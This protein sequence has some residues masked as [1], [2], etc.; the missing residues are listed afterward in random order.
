MASPVVFP[1][2]FCPCLTKKFTVIGTIG[3]TQGITSASSPPPAEKSRKANRPCSAF[4]ATSLA[5][6]SSASTA[7]A[8]PGTAAGPAG[9]ADGLAATAGDGGG[10]A[11]A[12]PP[13]KTVSST[14]GSV[15]R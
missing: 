14:S 8:S 2:F 11:A 12:S 10:G 6:G 3:Q 1:L 15:V 9:G 13:G 4:W 5:G 7:G